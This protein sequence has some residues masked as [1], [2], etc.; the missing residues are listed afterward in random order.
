M[1]R[2]CAA[3]YGDARGSNG[4]GVENL[5]LVMVVGSSVAAQIGNTD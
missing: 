4:I 1:N 5:R 3:A 2:D